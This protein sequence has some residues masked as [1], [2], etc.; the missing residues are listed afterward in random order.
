VLQDYKDITNRL[1]EP[2]WWD[3]AGVPRYFPFHPSYV[4]NI[5][6]TQVALLEIACQSCGTRFHVAMSTGP[7]DAY[8]LEEPVRRG[9]IH[10]GDPPNYGCCVSGPSMNCEDLRVLQFW[11]REFPVTW[12]RHPEL[13]IALPDMEEQFANFWSALSENP[14][15]F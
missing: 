9:F 14:E 12:E 5:Y 13:E 1:G 6:A 7:L 11:T 15:D 8:P 10:Y 4:N 2:M 3:E